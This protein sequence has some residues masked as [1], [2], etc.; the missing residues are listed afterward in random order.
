MYTVFVVSLICCIFMSVPPMIVE[1]PGRGVMAVQSGTVV[2]VNEKEVVVKALK[3]GIERRYAIK[4]R[5]NNPHGELEEN[6]REG[7]LL[8][9]KVVTWQRPVVEEG[10]QVKRKELLAAGLTRIF[11]QANIWIFTAL[12]LIL[13]AVMGIG[14]AA[15]YKYIPE[16]FPKD[17]GAVGGIVGL[18]GGLGG[19]ICP[20]IFGYLLNIT[21]LWTS[22]WMFFGLLVAGCLLW[23]HLVVQSMM[24]R[25]APHAA[26]AIE[27][28]SWQTLVRNVG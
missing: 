28:K 23:L 17:V 16:Y 13:G 6:F 24:K 15:V 11:F 12:S 26:R 20:V 14:K 1:T 27:Q 8:L 22:C 21:G 19:F 4:Y 5:S 9:P 2:A 7:F 3:S 18:L 25:E 10:Q